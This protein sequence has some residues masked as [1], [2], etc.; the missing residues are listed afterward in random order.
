[1]RGERATLGK[2]LLDVQRDL[3]IKASYITAIENCDAQAF[4]TP[5]FIPGYVRSYAKYLGMRPNE[6][7]EKFCLESGYCL[8]HGMS[9]S[10]S[11][12]SSALPTVAEG[13]TF[14]KNEVLFSNPNAA[15][16]PIK[17]SIFE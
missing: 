2:S 12:R 15:C 3:H 6:V 11:I 14:R 10:A 9:S 7:Y 16:V 4:D 13:P 17:E 5:G 1:M 8:A